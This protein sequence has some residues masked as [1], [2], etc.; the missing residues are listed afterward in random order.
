MTV[1][2][3]RVTSR[4]LH[5]HPARA[6]RMSQQGPVSITERGRPAYVL[7]TVADYE[8]MLARHT[9]SPGDAATMLA[10]STPR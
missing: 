10:P 7:M 3:T 4:E 1:L 8:Q 2:Q 6:R 9:E 5:R